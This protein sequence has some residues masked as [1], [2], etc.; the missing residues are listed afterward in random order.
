MAHPYTTRART[1]ALIGAATVLA[2]CD[3]A[4]DGVEDT[5]VYDGA[6]ERAANAVDS[7][8]RQYYVV[9][10]PTVG[11]CDGTVSDLCD[12]YAAHLLFSEDDPES[13]YA[14]MWLS[15]FEKIIA[16]LVS[17][18]AELSDAKVADADAGRVGISADYMDNE[19]GF[20]NS[21][22]TLVDRMRNF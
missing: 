1:E 10:F 18:E 14:R 19:C 5:G 22:G 21:T 8:L 2:L 15:K 7:S 16:K 20:D 12:Y 6:I 9:P 11:T 17:G 13:R 4:G 3:R